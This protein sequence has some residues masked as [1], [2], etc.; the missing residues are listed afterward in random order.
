MPA[1][2]AAAISSGSQNFQRDAGA[3][4][5]AADPVDAQRARAPQRRVGIGGDGR[6]R[7]RRHEAALQAERVGQ[8]ALHGAD[9]RVPLGG[10]GLEGALD[11]VD[12]AFRQVGPQVVQALALAAIV[13]PP[14]LGQ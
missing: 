12:E 1:A 14:Q 5:R 8:A 10:I 11:D 9:A 3:T 13:H 7:H 6:Q 2:S 4:G